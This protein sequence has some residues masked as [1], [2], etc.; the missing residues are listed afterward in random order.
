MTES[1]FLDRFDRHLARIDAHIDI[2]NRHLARN[3]ELMERNR[4]AVDRNSELME[5][6]K[7]E[8]RLTRDEVERS[9]ISH[10]G[11]REFTREITRRNEVVWRE[12]AA[13]LGDMR[14]E[15]RAQTQ[16]ILTVL[17]RLDTPPA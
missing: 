14:G 9:R 7:Q 2:A 16:A 6:V 4:E 1:E 3:S 13:T 11:L 8:I 15:I 12:V 5:E 17:D 10:E